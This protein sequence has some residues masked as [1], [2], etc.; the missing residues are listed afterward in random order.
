MSTGSI[1]QDKER[2][3]WWFVVD[4]PG[5]TGKRQQ[6]RR[7][8]FKTKKDATEAQ[9]LILVERARG[10]FV[11]PTR[12]TVGA[13]LADEWLPAK[14]PGLRPSTADTYAR[15]IELYVQPSIGGVELSQLD[16]SMLN[17]LYGRMLGS[18]RSDGRKSEHGG[19]LAPKTVR[20]LHGM[21]SKA[22][23]DGIRWGRLARNPCDAAD[24]PTSRSPEM[25][26]WTQEEL[27]SF[28]QATSDHRWAAIWALMITTGMRRGE[29]L[30]LR[31]SDIDL[32]TGSATIRSTRIRYGTT[33]DRSTPKTASGNR[34][35]AL[36]PSVRASLRT[37][38]KTQMEE[39]MLMGDGWQNDDNLVVTLADGR[40]PN[41]E[42]FSNLFQNLTRRAGLRTIRLHDLRHSYATAALASGIPVKVVSQRLGHADVGVTLKVYAHVLP[43]D[44][45]HA[46]SAADNLLSLQ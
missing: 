12:V 10:T 29:V 37:W 28:A 15:M 31:W 26:A 34:T 17:T 43:G 5:P 39:R 46:A 4:V 25:Q 20:N 7:R 42:S 11:R 21:L 14:R 24:P 40:A 33:V 41:P 8:G 6:L 44:D 3:T 38:R 27:R 32:D 9:A 13:Y 16:G 36:G 23:R 35:I 30:G 2:G 1:K 18:G 19:G 22:F 45:I